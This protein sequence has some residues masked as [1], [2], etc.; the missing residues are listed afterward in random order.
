MVPERQEPIVPLMFGTPLASRADSWLITSVCGD[1][2][3]GAPQYCG[4]KFKWS[5]RGP[6]VGR[7]LTL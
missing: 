4:T 1:G 3:F 7:P 6:V 5:V 2:S